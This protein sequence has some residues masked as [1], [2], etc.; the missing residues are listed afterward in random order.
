M[1]RS[2]TGVLTMLL[3][4]VFFAA[5][6]ALIRATPDVNSYILGMAR[7]VV[8]VLVCV[9]VFVVKLDRP[10]WV[11]WPWL[12][13][14]GVIGSIA[15]IIFFWSIQEI[16]LAKATVLNYTY[17][18]WAGVLAVP[19]LGERLRPLQWTAVALAVAGIV[20]LFEVHDF[21]VAP[22][23][24]MALLGGICSGIAVVAITRCR[25]TDSS[26]NVF[27]SQSLFGIVAV[28][29]PMAA[30]WPAG[31]RRPALHDLRLQAHRRH[32]GQ[33]AEPGDAGAGWGAGGGLLRRAPH[34]ALRGGDAAD[35][36]G[37]YVPGAQPGGARPAPD[38]G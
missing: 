12:V 6:A 30:Q 34:G 11:N 17:V 10:R 3:S 16:G 20:L 28:A 37:L 2:H 29:W 33:P 22:G 31:G 24:A 1:P 15:V 7:F 38:D 9:G 14:R 13:V 21:R 32:A 27:W 23:D 4:T 8:G 36:A 26:T 5:M 19:M 18:I 35:P 25:E